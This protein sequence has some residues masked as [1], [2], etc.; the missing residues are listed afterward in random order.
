MPGKAPEDV[1]Y[2]LLAPQSEP[3]IKGSQQ[4]RDQIGA[5]RQPEY[6]ERCEI[7]TAFSSLHGEQ[8]CQQ[9]QTEQYPFAMSAARQFNQR[10]WIPGIERRANQAA[11]RGD[12][13]QD[14]P[15]Q[16]NVEEM[17]A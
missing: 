11:C 16:H 4:Q 10:Q 5:N 14:G 8:N 3:G 15:D 17:C 7:I 9:Q 12:L 2:V 6:N 13:A 1:C